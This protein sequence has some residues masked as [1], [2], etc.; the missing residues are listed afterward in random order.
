[1][2][3][4]VQGQAS[5]NQNFKVGKASALDA[6]ILA[7]DL[8]NLTSYEIEFKYKG[9]IVSITNDEDRSGGSTDNNGLYILTG[10]DSTQ[11]SSWT[12]VGTGGG[13][14]L[15][16]L[17]SGDADKFLAVNDTEDGYEYQTI[18]I[19]DVS[20]FITSSDLPD[21][22]NF[23]T[24]SDLPDVSNFITSSDL[25]DVSNFIT[26][27]DLPDVSSFITSSDLPDVSSFITSSDLPDVSNFITS[28]DLPDVSNFITSSDLPFTSNSTELEVERNDLI[29]KSITNNVRPRLRF[30][31]K[32]NSGVLS[33]V[34]SISSGATDF[35]INSAAASINFQNE[36]SGS[37]V[38]RMRLTQNNNFCIGKSSGNGATDEMLT[39]VGKI[40]IENSARTK[41]RIT[42]VNTPQIVATGVINT[43]NAT[44][45]D[46][47]GGKVTRLTQGS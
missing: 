32:N 15:P 19:P 12:K 39:V 26:S 25:P 34:G 28:S 43:T 33:S 7:P 22:S 47:I 16:S 8:A 38:T 9:M 10:T 23:I 29:I 24:S 40:R 4:F 20:N 30:T 3:S 42:D 17:S 36:T 45:V 11:L 41:K 35:R 27:S 1:M 18:N 31:F 6:R 44:P 5:F 21:V 2:S 14:G 46:I 37:T 13:S